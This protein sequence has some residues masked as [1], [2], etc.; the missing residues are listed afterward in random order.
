[1]CLQNN[2]FKEPEIPKK[3]VPKE[4]IPVRTPEKLELPPAKGT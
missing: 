1:M 2:I 3:P 4:K